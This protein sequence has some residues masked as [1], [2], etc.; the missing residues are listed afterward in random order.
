MPIRKL[1]WLANPLTREFTTA[2]VRC[3]LQPRRLEATQ[4]VP[5]LA[6][7]EPGP[8][9]STMDADG[10]YN[11]YGWSPGKVPSM[12]PAENAWTLH[13]GTDFVLL[14]HLIAGARPETVQPMIG[15]FFSDTPPTRA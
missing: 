9:F 10:V 4:L 1:K 14:L 8:G 13:P 6:D 12:E 15:L 11:V 3:K 2:I 5:G 7:A